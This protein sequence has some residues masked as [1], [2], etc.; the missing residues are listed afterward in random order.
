MAC[1]PGGGAGSFGWFCTSASLQALYKKAAPQFVFETHRWRGRVC[2]QYL[3]GLTED[4]SW[5]Q[6]A[7]SMLGYRATTVVRATS[8]LVQLLRNLGRLW[9][10]TRQ[11]QHRL[12]RCLSPG[13]TLPHCLVTGS[14]LNCSQTPQSCR[15]VTTLSSFK[16]HF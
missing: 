9:G 11:A 15:Q 3:L 16:L 5:H 12:K 1:S 4:I 7:K 8:K 6:P 13:L 14:G 10:I 2:L